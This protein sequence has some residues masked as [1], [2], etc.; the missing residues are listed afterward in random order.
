MISEFGDAVCVDWTILGDKE[1]FAE[2]PAG[3]EKCF[4]LAHVLAVGLVTCCGVNNGKLARLVVS[5][6]VLWE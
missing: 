4:G 1:F 2:I 6:V 5:G 3:V